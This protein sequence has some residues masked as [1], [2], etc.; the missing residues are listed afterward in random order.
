MLVKRKCKRC[1]TEFIP[2][3]YRHAYCSRKCFE[4]EYQKKVD[5]Y[6]SYLCP[7]CGKITKLDFFPRMVL[8]SNKWNKFK[9]PHCGNRDKE[10]DD[11]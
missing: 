11:C 10:R 8:N 2:K 1:G 3:T 7:E 5:T 9:C 4:R 6:P